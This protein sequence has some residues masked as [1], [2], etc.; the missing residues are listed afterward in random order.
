MHLVL[1][2]AKVLKD[3]EPVLVA[4]YYI[5]RNFSEAGHIYV[6][7]AGRRWPHYFRRIEHAVQQLLSIRPDYSSH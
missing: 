2:I 3:Y 4:E 6:A 1:A 7:E 5:P